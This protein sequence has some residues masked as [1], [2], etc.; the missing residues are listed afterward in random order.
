MESGDFP[1]LAAIAAERD[2]L[3]AEKADLQE[4]LARRMAEFDNF[5]KRVE[6]EKAE[7]RD[8]STME[9]VRQ[10]LPFLDDMERA[11]NTE[12]ADK[13][14][15]RGMELIVRRLSAELQKLGLE[16]VQTEGQKFDPHFHHALEVQPSTEAE[17]HSILAEFQKGYLFRGKLLRPALVRVAA[18]PPVDRRTDK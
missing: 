6:R 18:P 5:R 17:D 3:A 15:A 16:P 11:L 8:F 14:Y 13:D 12:T 1:Q 9:T 2:Q 4:R 10:F 7:L